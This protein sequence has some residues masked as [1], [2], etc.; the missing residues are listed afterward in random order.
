[1]A[2]TPAIPSAH[3]A[4]HVAPALPGK[5]ADFLLAEYKAL[6]DEILKRLEMQHQLIS[7][8][9]VAA[10]GLFAAGITNWSAVPP[11]LYPLL[12]LFLAVSWTLHDIRI[13]EMGMYIR[14][15][16]EAQLLGHAH[17]WEHLR[18]A[19]DARAVTHHGW[20]SRGALRSIFAST[21][22]LAVLL[23][24]LMGSLPAP[25]GHDAI[26][27]GLKVEEWLPP[28]GVYQLAAM[29]LPSLKVQGVLLL[30]GVVLPFVT[31]CL[32]LV[33]R[34]RFNRFRNG[35]PTRYPPLPTVN[36]KVRRW[37]PQLAMGSRGI[38]PVVHT[39]RL[40]ANSV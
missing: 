27:L 33:Y 30:L 11:L 36:G 16:I 40:V 25:Q 19:Q 3:S 35:Y 8:A 29:P 9:L 28:S 5:E 39:L 21:Q 34:R 20:H 14:G 12:S 23:A 1:M 24:W 38:R 13:G 7:F 18:F 26:D 17:G 4:A 32:P 37:G 22:A 2:S 6:R 31:C 10:G 15:R